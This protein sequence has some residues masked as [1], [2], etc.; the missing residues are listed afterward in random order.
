M[1]HRGPDGE[2][3][4]EVPEHDLVLEHVRLAVIDPANREADQPFSDPSGRWTMVY[5]GE[6]F[7]FRELRGELERAGVR[8]TTES[9]TEVVLQAFLNWGPDAFSRLRGMFALV[10]A[11][12]VTGELVAA[13]DQVGVKPLYWSFRGGL[14]LAASE[15]RTITGHPGQANALDHPGVVE[16]L[17]FG[18]NGEERT[19][20]E[21]VH[22]LRPG[23]WLRLAEGRVETHEYWDVVPAD[24]PDKTHLVEDLSDRIED[25]VRAALVSDVPV[26]MMLSGGFDSSTIA[27]LA[28]RL[29]D[30]AGLTAYSVSFGLPSDESD[31]AARLARTLGIRHRVITLGTEDITS[32]M[33][34]WLDQMDAPSAN[35][36]WIAVSH[37]AR[38]VHEDGG[39]VLLSGD[40][41]DELFGGYDRWMTYLRFHDRVWAP[42]PRIVRRAGGT[43][44]SPILRGL[45]G[46]MARR[47]RDGGE[48][49]VESRPFHDDDLRLTLGPAGKR[50]AHAHPPERSIAEIRARFDS[51]LPGGDYL[52][53]MSYL[54]LKAGLVED[55]LARLDKMGMAHSVEGRVP[56]LDAGLARWALA[57][58]Q[59]L[60]VPGFRNKA[61][62]REAVEPL[63]PAFITSR[64]KQGFCPPVAAWATAALPVT[65]AP[66]TALVDSG[67]VMAGAA[68]ALRAKGGDNASFALWTLGTLDAWCERHL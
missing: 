45:A 15:L 49:F 16:Y 39:K 31:A 63:L 61:L 20:L 51:R 24:A 40:G 41:G 55:F 54:S 34:A 32:G 53:W 26:S 60:K 43:M 67:L 25:S 10:V 66:G 33:G 13:R 47:A 11:D 14:F 2:G 28:S 46:D 21:G 22:K 27:V 35:P 6:V 17:A 59:S 57:T 68:D 8:F 50:A 7:N 42:T 62:F 44:I 4:A 1:G 58:P 37:I 30:P 23:T 36:T 5:N 48:L 56:L 65:S 19:F 9:D 52:A 29:V 64:P 38:A 18:H 12:L 3:V